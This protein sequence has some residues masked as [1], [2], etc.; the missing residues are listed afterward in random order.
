MH[1]QMDVV[2][3]DSAKDLDEV[4][5]TAR[6][7]DAPP[8]S[9]VHRVSSTE[10]AIP[11]LKSVTDEFVK[12]LKDNRKVWAL[13]GAKDR[14]GITVRTYIESSYRNDRSRVYDC[15]WRVLNVVPEA[16]FDFKTALVPAASEEIDDHENVNFYRR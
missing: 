13:Y 14:Q 15:E 16:D 10:P 6:Q 12:L 7:L 5:D 8:P 4:I 1:T 9:E 11:S 2:E 3:P